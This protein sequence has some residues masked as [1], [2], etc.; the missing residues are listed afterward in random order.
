MFDREQGLRYEAPRAKDDEAIDAMLQR[1]RTLY[2]TRERATNPEG[3]PV[4]LPAS[5]PTS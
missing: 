2:G 3:Y 4:P 1:V 5:R